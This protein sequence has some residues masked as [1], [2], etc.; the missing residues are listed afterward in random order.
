MHIDRRINWWDEEEFS[1]I[2]KIESEN[3]GTIQPTII[4][5]HPGS[6]T[7]PG[8]PRLYS[9]LPLYLYAL[10]SFGMEVLALGW[11]PLRFLRV[12]RKTVER[13]S[14]PVPSQVISA[15]GELTHLVL[16]E[17][18]RPNSLR[19]SFRAQCFQLRS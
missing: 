2:P 9:A 7:T 3:A 10:V 1:E 5:M 8:E 12:S 19:V 14:S 18:D 16:L 4:I 17:L 13:R 6:D 11:S 15:G